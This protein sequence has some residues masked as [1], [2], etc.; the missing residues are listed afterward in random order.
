MKKRYMEP[1]NHKSIDKY[2]FKKIHVNSNE[3]TGYVG[4]VNIKHVKNV[5]HVPRKNGKT[6]CILNSGYKWLEFYPNNEKYAITALC[7]NRKEV[8]EWYFDMVKDFGI[9]DGMPYMNDLYLDLVITRKGEIYILDEDE[10]LEALQTKDITKKDY[11]MAYETMNMLL[12]KY[13][14]GKN[15]DELVDLTN[16]YLGEF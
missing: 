3:F 12:K 7:N 5:W 10:L 16:K 14:N 13:D 9:E 6:E 11:D 15:I 4:F 2:N 8:V 1:I